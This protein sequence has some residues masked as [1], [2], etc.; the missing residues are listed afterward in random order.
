MH[1][2]AAYLADFDP[3]TVAAIVTFLEDVYP[4]LVERARSRGW[5]T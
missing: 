4:G 5:E 3:A 1:D 2:P